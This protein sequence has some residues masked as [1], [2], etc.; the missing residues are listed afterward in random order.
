VQIRDTTV[1]DLPQIDLIRHANEPWHVTNLEAQANWFN[2]A[3][4]ETKPFRICVEIDGRVVANGSVK[5]DLY[6]ATADSAIVAVNV[7]PEVRGQGIGGRLF[8]R[9]EEHLHAI[10]AVQALGQLVEAPHNVAFAQKHGF[11]LGATDR[12]IVV[13]P[14]VLPPVPEMA[15]AVAVTTAAE[16]GPEAWYAV[17]DI[18]A[19]DEPLDEPLHRHALRGLVQDALEL[20]RQRRQPH[21]VRRRQARRDHGTRRGLRQRQGD[22]GWYGCVA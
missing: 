18:A 22:F 14:R 11:T 4:P 7:H 2:S 13:D 9:M 17:V 3:G 8:A 20:V 12:W 5:L 15:A 21:R 6:G 10:G 1:E 16:A 19:R